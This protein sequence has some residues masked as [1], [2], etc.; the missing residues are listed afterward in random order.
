MNTRYGP[1]CLGG[2]T[3]SDVSASQLANLYVLNGLLDGLQDDLDIRLHH[4]SMLQ[5]ANVDR[6]VQICREINFEP[7]NIQLD[8]LQDLFDEDERR[9]KEQM[10]QQ[11]L[12][13]YNDPQS[14]F[15]AVKSRTI[16]TP[17]APHFLSMLQHLLLMREDG[18]ALTNYYRLL[19]N[20]VSDIVLDKKLAGAEGRL[21]SSVT[22]IIAAMNDSER[23]QALEDEAQELRA[24]ALRLKLEKDALQEEV[25]E[26]EAGMVGR[27]KE[28]LARSEDKVGV[29]RATTTRLQGQLETQKAGYEEQINQLEAQIMELFRILKELGKELGHGVNSIIER[30]SA[31]DRKQL[32]A[33]LDR[34]MQRTKT[35]DILEGRNGAPRRAKQSQFEDGDELLDDDEAAANARRDQKSASK[36]G[37]NGIGQAQGMPRVSQFMDADDAEEEEQ[38]QQQLA[39]GVFMVGSRSSCGDFQIID[40]SLATASSPRRCQVQ[41]SSHEIFSQRTTYSS[42]RP[43]SSPSTSG[44][45]R[46]TERSKYELSR[47]GRSDGRA[48][49]HPI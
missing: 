41:C 11:I 49:H 45:R 7:L 4:R 10:D 37:K 28:T 40:L 32:V 26:G 46:R 22:R 42:S 16:G 1:L 33:T 38:I 30:E 24:Q 25:A 47:R 18:L 13:D 14:V 39:A 19:D 9:L 36:A 15:D 12:Q 8:Y 31:M 43:W 23:V 27:L 44:G 6:I 29:L 35:I 17:A 2:S 20:V 48:R 3:G 21:G 5:K 34:Y